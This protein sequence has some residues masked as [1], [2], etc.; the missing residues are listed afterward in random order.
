MAARRVIDAIYDS[1]RRYGFLLLA[2]TNVNW[3]KVQTA[4]RSWA[5]SIDPARP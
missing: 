2:N 1:S 3:P 5:M 4:F